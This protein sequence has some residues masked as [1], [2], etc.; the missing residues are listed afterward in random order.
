MKDY[1]LDDFDFNKALGEI[2]QSI[3]KPNIR[4]LILM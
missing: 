3:A 1:R 2:S 4:I